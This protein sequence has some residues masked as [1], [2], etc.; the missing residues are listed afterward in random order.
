MDYRNIALELYGWLDEALTSLIDL[1]DSEDGEYAVP[2]A[3]AQ[4][5]C[6]YYLRKLGDDIPPTLLEECFAEGWA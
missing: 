5:Y 1:D 4:S 2:I 6:A 3:I